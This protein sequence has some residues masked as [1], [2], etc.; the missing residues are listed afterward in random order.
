VASSLKTAPA[1][2]I[3]QLATSPEVERAL[4]FF[5]ANA[6]AITD[7]HIRICTIPASPFTEQER[8]EYLAE[9]FRQLGLHEVSLD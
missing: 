2:T 3:R 4:H 6:D 9:R 1:K 5:A 8:A 7:E